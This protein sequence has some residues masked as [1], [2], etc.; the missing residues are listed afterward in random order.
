MTLEE[1]SE[2]VAYWCG[3]LQLDPW[4]VSVSVT[5]TPHGNQK[6]SVNAS[7]GTAKSYLY[8][9][10]EFAE[11]WIESDPS[12]YDRDQ[13]IVHELLHCLFRDL[14]SAAEAPFALLGPIIEDANEARYDHEQEQLIDRLAHV[15]VLL[16]DRIPE[17]TPASSAD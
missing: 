11:A 5:D 4:H 3:Q 12:N 17:E 2:R 6:D 10:I 9:E 14:D 15:I 13:T 16:H 8:A 7:V 1:L